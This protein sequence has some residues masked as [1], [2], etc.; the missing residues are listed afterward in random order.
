MN[1]FDHLIGLLAPAEC[2]GCCREGASLCDSC[3]LKITKP[4]QETCFGCNKLSVNCST[5]EKCR[6]IIGVKAAYAALAY[7]STI[8]SLVAKYKFD[9]LRD[10]ANQL[11]YLMADMGQSFIASLPGDAVVVPV[12]VV[13]SHIRQRGFDHSAL[14]AKK[15]A[16][17]VNLPCLL[18]IKRRDQKRQVGAKRSVRLRQL[19]DAFYVP[20]SRSFTVKGRDI[21]LIDDISTTGAT[22][23]EATQA[24]RAAGAKQVFG[25][26]LAKKELNSMAN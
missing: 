18:V 7:N 13:T 23:K 15:F 26:V 11:A 1:V 17:L 14:L 2:L 9:H 24:L 22:L 4:Y 8:K 16:H 25:L 19:Q 10:A 20:E 6:S 3:S 12:P 21:L 5:C